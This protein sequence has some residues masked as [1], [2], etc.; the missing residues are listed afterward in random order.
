MLNDILAS[1]DQGRFQFFPV[2]NEATSFSSKNF[3][4]QAREPSFP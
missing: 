2:N 4:W 3:V 1:F